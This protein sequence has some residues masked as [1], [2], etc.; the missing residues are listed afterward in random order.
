[1]VWIY[2][3]LL[4]AFVISTIP[5]VVKYYCIPKSKTDSKFKNSLSM[6]ESYFPVIKK[7]FGRVKVL[8]LGFV[9]KME[10][11]KKHRRFYQLVLLLVMMAVQV[12]NA[13]ASI[14]SFKI[15]CNN[16]Q[17][18]CET[19][20]RSKIDVLGLGL[21]RVNSG[22]AWNTVIPLQNLM[23]MICILLLLKY[24]YMDR[25]LSFIHRN[26]LLQVVMFSFIVIFLFEPSGSS[27]MIAEFMYLLLCGS[28]AYPNFNSEKSKKYYA[29]KV[30]RNNKKSS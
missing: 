23:L 27:F 15:L 13:N 7:Q 2:L 28:I 3:K 24:K 17:Y 30:I 1:M 6:L 25:L 12:A 10:I 26:K 4:L 18:Y 8:I 19:F 29:I 16:T 20:Q 14:S 9:R 22:L 5:F 21:L 11:S